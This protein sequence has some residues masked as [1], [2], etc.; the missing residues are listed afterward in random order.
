MIRCKVFRSPALSLGLV[1]TGG[2]AAAMLAQ[3]CT[4]SVTGPIP[5]V[6]PE[7]SGNIPPTLTITQPTEDLSVERGGR[8]RRTAVVH[9]RARRAVRDSLDRH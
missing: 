4:T 7:V 1:L 2:L 3:S 6:G 5:T 9:Q 8:W